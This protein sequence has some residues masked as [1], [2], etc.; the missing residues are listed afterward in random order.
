MTRRKF[1]RSFLRLFATFCTLSLF[2]VFYGN[3][4]IINDLS[5]GPNYDSADTTS[6][7]EQLSSKQIT[8]EENNILLARNVKLQP[9]D[10]R[11]ILQQ[12]FELKT[13]EQDLR[14]SKEN[15]RPTEVYFGCKDIRDTQILDEVG[16]GY[17]KSVQKGLIN[18][19]LYA[20]K[21]VLERS[22]DF[23]HCLNNGANYSQDHCFNLVKYKLAKEIILLQQLKHPNIIKVGMK[24]LFNC[25]KNIRI[26]SQ[27]AFLS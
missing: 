22:K 10:K 7:R 6:D 1:H 14:N 21:S 16:H 2:Y 27:N 3:I 17:T 5:S 4:R 19:K 18:G 25:H 24:Q 8:N 20:V 15:K 11:R 12:Y 9:K 23:Q 26:Y 13:G